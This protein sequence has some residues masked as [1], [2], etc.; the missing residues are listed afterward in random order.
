MSEPDFPELPGEYS[1]IDLYIDGPGDLQFPDTGVSMIGNGNRGSIG[2]TTDFVRLKIM[3]ESG[4]VL[5]SPNPYSFDDDRQVDNLVAEGNNIYTLRTGILYGGYSFLFR[6]IPIETNVITDFR[7]PGYNYYTYLG[8]SRYRDYNASYNSL[9]G[10]DTARTKVLPRCQGMLVSYSMADSGSAIEGARFES[11]EGISLRIP[12]TTDIVRSGQKIRMR[13]HG[14]LDQ[15]ELTDWDTAV[16]VYYHNN[17]SV[18]E[19]FLSRA[20]GEVGQDGNSLWVELELLEA[21]THIQIDLVPKKIAV[22]VNTTSSWQASTDGA[23]IHVGQSLVLDLYGPDRE[24]IVDVEAPIEIERI[25]SKLWKLRV[26]E[27]QNPITI[28]IS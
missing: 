7:V 27:I 8:N 13:Y 9:T 18:Y 3:P 22:T 2:T 15:Y 17:T 19:T 21:I 6:F 5:D 20:S 24:P 11:T 26:I 1:K 25:S 4:Y 23:Q 16:M 10:S 28:N 12:S 14:L